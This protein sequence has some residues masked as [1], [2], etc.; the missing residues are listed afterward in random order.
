[1]ECVIINIQILIK[2]DDLGSLDEYLKYLSSVSSYHNS[3]GNK[4][5]Y[6]LRHNLYKSTYHSNNP[7]DE[8]EYNE[9]TTEYNRYNWLEKKQIKKA[10]GEYP[11]TYYSGHLDPD[12]F[13]TDWN[14]ID[15]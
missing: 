2:H 14:Y 15:G 5:G 6:D 12:K 13:I 8:F 10:T 3:N 1:M 11:K 7:I 4:R 9:I